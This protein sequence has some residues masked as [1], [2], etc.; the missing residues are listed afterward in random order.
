MRWRHGK[1]TDVLQITI[2]LGVVQ[3]IA[4]HKLVGNL[5]ADVV[6]FD[7][8]NN[9]PLRLIEQRGD[10]QDA[11]SPLH[12]DALDVAKGEAGVQD[13]LD[14][15]YVEP[16]DAGVEVLRQ[17]DLTRSLL[18]VAVTRDGHEIERNLEVNLADEV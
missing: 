9:A 17:A 4:H 8:F 2:A 14:Q 13:V 12:Q 7:F 18:I 5:E 10:A 11:R 3:T 6:G 16:L 1:D 15:D